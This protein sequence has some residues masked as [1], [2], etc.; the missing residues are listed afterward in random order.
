MTQSHWLRGRT[1]VYNHMPKVTQT[2]RR[3]R[4]GRILWGAFKRTSMVLGA[5][6][7]ISSL[8]SIIIFS[9]SM[10]QKAPSLP[11]QM[12]LVHE[13]SDSIPQTQ[14]TAS[15]FVEFGFAPQKLTLDEMVTSLDGASQD[16]RVK[17]YV[18]VLRSGSYTLAQLQELRA[19]IG[20][21]KESKKPTYIF[22]SSYGDVGSGLGVYFLATVFDQIWLQPIGTVSILGLNAQ[23][24]YFR[25]VLDKYGIQPQFFQRK[26]YKTAMENFTARE[27]S[28]AS[29]EMTTFLVN[30]LAD[31][32]LSEISKSRPR[33]GDVK[34][35]VDQGLF[36][37]VEAKKQGLVDHVD[38]SDRLVDAVQLSVKKDKKEADLDLINLEAYA[39]N[40]HSKETTSLSARKTV[41][42]ISI[43]GLIADADI[44]G[45]PLTMNQD[46]VKASKIA[47]AIREAGRDDSIAAIMIRVDS[48]GGT[49]TAAETI[50]RAIIWTRQEYKK[51]VFVTMGTTAASGGYWVASAADRIFALPSTLTGSIGVVGGKMN[52]SQLMREHNVNIDGVS[53]GANADML[54]PFAP[55]STS[56]QMQFEKSLDRVYQYFTQIVADGRR[57]TLPQVEE[58]A[59][60]RVWTGRQAKDFK[61]VDDLGGAVEAYDALAKTLG[62]TSRN[63]LNVIELP[64]PESP[65]EAVIELLERGSPFALSRQIEMVVESFSGKALVI[66][67]LTVQ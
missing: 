2:P 45:S 62:V 12:I 28:P 17:A 7:L 4:V 20:R 9:Q 22:A 29:R 35:L 6:M 38:Y 41:A 40:L 58:L 53:F 55:F 50:R 32:M 44:G 56:S 60:G 1:V 31:Q 61:L 37:D 64:K 46:V 42:Q 34:S 27:M 19:A 24:P 47:Q 49:P 43:Q 15:Y 10:N 52:I 13:L 3:F 5:V 16:E 21:F 59:Q 26:D 14:S 54:S 57:M 11:S 51:P 25:G 33:L 66:E 63:D 23:M 36:T 48:P 18:L 8:I 30:D 39:N 65:F 67:P